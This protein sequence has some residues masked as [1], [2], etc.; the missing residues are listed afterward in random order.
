MDILGISY[1]KL[2]GK[3]SFI[4]DGIFYEVNE[5]NVIKRAFK[6]YTLNNSVVTN[7]EKTYLPIA[8]I[9]ELLGYESD[10]NADRNM[11]SISEKTAPDQ[12]SN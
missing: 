1:V 10:Y 12:S 5:G 11:M 4:K 7:G 3:I 8:E 2:G 9:S 6:D